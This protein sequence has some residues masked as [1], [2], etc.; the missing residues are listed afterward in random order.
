MFVVL[1]QPWAGL[2]EVGV[3]EKMFL[4]QEMMSIRNLISCILLLLHQFMRLLHRSVVQMSLVKG[5]KSGT[6]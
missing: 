6:T 1:F 3:V 4:P 5:Q 2:G